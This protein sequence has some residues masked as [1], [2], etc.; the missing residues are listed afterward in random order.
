MQMNSGFVNKQDEEHDRYIAPFFSD[1]LVCC[2][3][4]V[5]C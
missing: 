3:S 5:L 2:F 4:D 1:D